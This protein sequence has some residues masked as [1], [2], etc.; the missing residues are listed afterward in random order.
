MTQPFLEIEAINKDFGGISAITDVS[1]SMGRDE[2]LG[3]YCWEVFQAD[4]CKTGCFLQATLEDGISRRDQHATP[5]AA[6]RP[7]AS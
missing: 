7:P 1:F 3:R 4:R 6:G 5:C 2:V